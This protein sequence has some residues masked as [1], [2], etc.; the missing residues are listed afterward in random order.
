[1][2]LQQ[3][4]QWDKLLRMGLRL[5][6]ILAI[7]ASIAQAEEQ[8]GLHT[9]WRLNLADIVTE[10][11]ESGGTK[12]GVFGLSF[13]PDGQQIAV[14]TGHPWD[15]EYVLILNIADPETKARILDVK[16][17]YSQIVADY[18][19]SV[20]WSMSGEQILLGHTLYQM[21]EK[22]SCFVSPF[23]RGETIKDLYFSAANEFIGSSWN[24][25]LFYN[26]ACQ[27][28]LNV[29]SENGCSIVDVSA[30]RKLLCIA[31]KTLNEVYIVDT[32]SR[33]V[34]MKVPFGTYR[35]AHFAENGKVIC[36]VMQGEW[37]HD[38]VSCRD[39]DTGKEIA[40]TPKYNRVV[41]TPAL[42]A[43]RIIL[44]GLGRKLE[45]DHFS[46][47]DGPVRQRTVWDYRT[48]RELLSW[49]PKTQKMP[50]VT[51]GPHYYQ[52][53]DQPYSFAVSPD[54]NYIVEGGEGTLTL[55]KIAAK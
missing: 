26:F 15:E 47:I 37:Y 46:W 25:L 34:R 1:M 49:K 41:I 14:V 17:G 8:W 35:T 28:T 31:N 13:S 29:E 48:G 33:K 10:R 38:V 7:T 55:Y 21:P 19:L 20:S 44:S 12:L 24:R 2:I 5:M 32:S 45:L 27:V 36:G 9:I 51:I 54:G 39:V 40:N 53:I 42:S 23:D 18:S 6:L 4:S 11:N 50:K 30:E 43:P 16:P 22:I 3:S 52:K